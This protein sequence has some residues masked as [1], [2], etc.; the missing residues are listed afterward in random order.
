MLLALDLQNYE[1][2]FFGSYEVGPIVMETVAV[3][4]WSQ[5]GVAEFALHVFPDNLDG[6]IIFG[7]FMLLEEPLL[8]AFQMCVLH[9]SGAFTNG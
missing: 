3:E 7:A 8:N 1:W 9:C 5:R 6:L 2:P 4:L